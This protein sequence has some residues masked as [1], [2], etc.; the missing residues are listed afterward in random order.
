MQAELSMVQALPNAEYPIDITS[1]GKAQLKSGAFEE[2]AAPGSAT[3]TQVT[4][5]GQQAVGDLNGDGLQDAVVTL[6]VDP[7]GSGTFT[8]LAAVI[9]QNGTPKPVASISIGDRIIVQSL[10]IQSSEII[11][12]YLTR[13]PEE[14]MS[15]P[16]TV[17]VTQIYKLQGN[18]LVE[19]K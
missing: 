6:I 9:N 12:I 19:Q 8:Y 2:T 15:A 7:G 11:V 16:P 1:T 14:P 3:M 4:L 17:E 18:E 5:G 13:K 10:V